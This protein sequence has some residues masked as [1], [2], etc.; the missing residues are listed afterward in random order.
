[1]PSSPRRAERTSVSASNEEYKYKN[2]V[3]EIYPDDL[4]TQQWLKLVLTLPLTKP[5]LAAGSLKSPTRKKAVSPT[6]KSPSRKP[7]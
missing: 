5:K 4:K 6:K 7:R 1:M 2:L 3:E